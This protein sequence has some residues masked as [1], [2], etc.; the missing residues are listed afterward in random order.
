MQL[1][2]EDSEQ[3]I[4]HETTA[5]A[6]TSNAW[7]SQTVATSVQAV[8]NESTR[9]SSVTEKLIENESQSAEVATTDIVI[10]SPSPE[11]LSEVILLQKEILGDNQSEQPETSQEQTIRDEESLCEEETCEGV[12][13]ELPEHNLEQKLEAK[14]SKADQENSV[15]VVIVSRALF[16]S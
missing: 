4:T 16:V 6:V 14:P 3:F 11:P 9:V 5:W 1:E 12:A 7:S 10:D 8:Q 13:H 15:D 2:S